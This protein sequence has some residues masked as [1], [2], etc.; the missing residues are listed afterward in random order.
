MMMATSDP[1]RSSRQVFDAIHA[2]H[3][4]VEQHQVE[5]LLAHD[6]KRGLSAARVRHFVA[7]RG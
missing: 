4:H 3:V 1:W 7:L 5:A 2:R 6:F